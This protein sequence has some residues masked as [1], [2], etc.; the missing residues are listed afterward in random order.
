MVPVVVPVVATVVVPVV[1]PVVATVL[2]VA[3]EATVVLL[4]TRS[5]SLHDTR[6]KHPATA[7]A[8]TDAGRCI[9]E[10]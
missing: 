10:Q 8:A 7:I 6:I 9:G 2:V 1:V 5:D 4:D 3:E